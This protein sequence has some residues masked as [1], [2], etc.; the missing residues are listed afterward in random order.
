MS[1]GSGSARTLPLPLPLLIFCSGGRRG[2]E[3]VSMVGRYLIRVR[4]RLGLGSMVGRY[5][6]RVRVRVVSVCS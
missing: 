3:T 6:V 1:D 4:V 2:A 5:L